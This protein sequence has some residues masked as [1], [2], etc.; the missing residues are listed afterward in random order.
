MKFGYY[1]C[2]VKD[3]KNI[4][5]IVADYF[6]VAMPSPQSELNYRNDFEL[7]VAVILSA[8]CTDKRVN[9]VTKALFEAMPTAGAMARASEDDIFSYIKSVSYPNA[10]ANHLHSMAVALCEHHAGV[11]PSTRAELEA[12]AGVGRKTASVILAVAFGEAEFAVDTHVFRVAARIGLSKNAKNV[13]Q[14]ERQLVEGF[15]KAISKEL[16]PDVHHWLILHGRYTCTARSPKCSEC[17]LREN[18]IYYRDRQAPQK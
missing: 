8:Q 16:L 4:F 6:S 9:I 17:G 11:V 13:L 3:T 5:K 2:G 12:L 10:K 18:C 14:T 1:L 15:S 7:L